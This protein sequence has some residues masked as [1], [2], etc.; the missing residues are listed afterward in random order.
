MDGKNI[1]FPFT[2]RGKTAEGWCDTYYEYQ[3]P[4]QPILRTCSNGISF[5]KAEQECYYNP[6]ILKMDRSELEFSLDFYYGYVKGNLII[7]DISNITKKFAAK[8]I[9]VIACWS[10]KELDFVWRDYCSRPENRYV[11]E[12]EYPFENNTLVVPLNFNSYYSNMTHFTI[13]VSQVK[14]GYDLS[15][16]KMFDYYHKSIYTKYIYI[17]K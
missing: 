12:H 6:P 17:I 2:I 3:D 14:N 16:S 1:H 8:T 5:D 15:M 4:G 13:M 10:D 11:G 9:Y 7:N